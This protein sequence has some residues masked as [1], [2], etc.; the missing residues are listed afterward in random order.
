[1]MK[2]FPLLSLSALVLLATLNLSG[3]QTTP[4]APPEPVAQP[5]PPPPPPEPPKPVLDPTAL[6]EKALAEAVALY[7]EGRYEDAISA[8]L[9]L[10][11]AAEL[12]MSSQVR[13]WK[14]LAFSNCASGNVRNCR[15]AFDNALALDPTFQLTDAERGHPVWGREFSRAR[16]AAMSKRRSTPA[17][18]R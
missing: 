13:A 7:N 17:S 5:L 8:L 15:S 6:K 11:T 9:P 16:A 2:K 4:V 1:M 14:F 18:T 3:C 12:P 10:T